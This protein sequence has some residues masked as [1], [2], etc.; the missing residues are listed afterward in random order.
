MSFVLFVAFC[1]WFRNQAL[2]P[3]SSDAA[4]R[5][6]S[7]D[8]SKLQN[9]KALHANGV[10]EQRSGSAIQGSSLK[11]LLTQQHRLIVL[12]RRNVIHERLEIHEK[13]ST[14]TRETSRPR[15]QQE[16]TFS[17]R[18]GARGWSLGL[19]VSGLI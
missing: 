18:R 17:Q 15:N 6:P 16:V 11:N 8:W 5:P 2:S 12:T 1:S 14:S 13:K 9:S 7:C 10:L 19:A 3:L 4:H